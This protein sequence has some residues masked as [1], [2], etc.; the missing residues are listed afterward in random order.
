MTI[1][2]KYWLVCAICIP[3]LA[4]SEPA[5]AQSEPRDAP[6]VADV[7]DVA[8]AEAR[9]RYAAE[10]VWFEDSYFGSWRPI[11]DVRG[12][13]A[14][15]GR[16][17]ERLDGGSFYR[18][19]G[20]EDLAGRYKRRSGARVAL[21]VGGL[22]V[23]VGG[24]AYALFGPEDCRL[25]AGFA[26]CLDRNSSRFNTGIVISLVG[27]GLAT[28]GF[29]INPHPISAHEARALADAHNAGLRED[30]GL[31]AHY[32]LEPVSYREE[33]RIRVAPFVTPEGG[34]IL[35]SGRL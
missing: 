16:H 8:D 3:A 25:G 10:Y 23:A 29:L 5:W 17:K 9:Q 1:V 14:Y 15:K 26:A 20:R 4:Y 35:V 6:D 13:L 24:T 12:T 30:L 2:K 7:A 31:P 27:G 11:W 21:V 18:A 28:A 22:G 32:E 34:G 19:V 33:E